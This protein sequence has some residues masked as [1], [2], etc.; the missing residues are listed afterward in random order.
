MI[1]FCLLNGAKLYEEDISYVEEI[2]Y[3]LKNGHIKYKSLTH[4]NKLK[5]KDNLEVNEIKIQHE[6]FEA[7]IQKSLSNILIP[8]LINI[9]TDFSTL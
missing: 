9:I 7:E 8:P 6:N 2:I 1:D 3:L 4:E 5:C